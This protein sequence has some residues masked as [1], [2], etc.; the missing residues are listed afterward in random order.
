MSLWKYICETND[1]RV[2]EMF[3]THLESPLGFFLII[4]DQKNLKGCLWCVQ[5]Q[6]DISVDSKHQTLQGVAFPLHRDAVEALK[7]YKDKVI[8]YV[9]LVSP[10]VRRRQRRPRVDTTWR[11]VCKARFWSSHWYSPAS[12]H[13]G[14]QWD[15]CGASPALPRLPLFL[16]S[17]RCCLFRTTAADLSNRR[18]WPSPHCFCW[19]AGFARLANQDD[20]SSPRSKANRRRTGSD[21]VV[22]HRAD[23]GQRPADEDPQ[24]CRSLPLLPLQTLPRRRLP[25]VH[26]WVAVHG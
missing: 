19:G 24:R 26:G 16:L 15:H 3:V 10:R 20:L 11:S 2:F 4:I 7:R 8:N 6:T 18:A 22:Q 14:V 13:I 17:P 5:V 1:Q 9:Q 25:A 12:C 23:G 21:P